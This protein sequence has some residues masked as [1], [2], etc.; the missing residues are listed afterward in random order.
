M[1]RL[2]FLLTYPFLWGVSKLPFRLLYLLSD[3]L[4]FIIYK[5]VRYRRKVVKENLELVFPEKS[6]QERHRI[7]RAF[8]AHMCDMFLEMIKT[9][10]ISEED[11]Q[12]HFTFTNLETFRQFEAQDKSTVTFFPHYASWE[13]TIALDPHIKSKGYGVYQTLN[14]KYFDRWVRRVRARLGTSLITTNESWKV[15]GRNNAEGIVATYGM[16]NDQSPTRKKARYWA[17]FMGITVPM[18]VGGETLCKKFDLPA[19]YLKVRKIKRGYYQGTFIVLSAAPKTVPA[20]EITDAFF[21]EL[22][23]A[24]R[25]APE[26]YFWTHKR[27]KHRNKAPKGTTSP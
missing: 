25:E 23:I 22:E 18:H 9:M 11:L 6:S 13:W 20:Y 12:K 10:N 8:Y 21:R 14:N 26:Y 27:W 7:A 2:V 5:V 15:M 19:L 24:I 1:Q 3:G 17:P 16:L 4:F